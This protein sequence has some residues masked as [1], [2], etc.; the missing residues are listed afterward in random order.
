MSIHF[1]S[2]YFTME[3]GAP[4]EMNNPRSRAAS[5]SSGSEL[6]G[7]RCRARSSTSS[8]AFPDFQSKQRHS[9]SSIISQEGS[10]NYSSPASP[11]TPRSRRDRSAKLQSTR[12]IRS[13]T[14]SLVGLERDKRGHKQT[15]SD[16][17]KGGLE[18]ALGTFEQ[19]K[20][21]KTKMGFAE[22][23]K[24]I[25]VQQKTFTKW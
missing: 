12:L 15:G 10:P 4:I 7:V 16:P 17:S 22:Q 6:S 1:P 18:E 2:Q 24:W 9:T 25:T 14:T 21:F 20:E 11:P 19:P 13:A 5:P 8:T 23:Q 3:L